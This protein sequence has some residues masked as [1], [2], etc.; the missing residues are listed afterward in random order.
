MITLISRRN[1][2]M[3]WTDF[4]FLRW[5]SVWQPNNKVCSNLNLLS[6][7][8]KIVLEFCS[9]LQWSPATFDLFE[10]SLKNW[11][12]ASFLSDEER[13]RMTGFIYLSSLIEYFRIPSLIK[14]LAIYSFSISQVWRCNGMVKNEQNQA[15]EKKREKAGVTFTCFLYVTWQINRLRRFKGCARVKRKW[16]FYL[17]LRSFFY[18]NAPFHWSIRNVWYLQ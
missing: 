11:N 4:S 10:I 3:V 15:A 9:F 14:V 17:A 7:W 12:D 5:A 13:W 8:E 18:S 2:S 16:S 1:C 6:R